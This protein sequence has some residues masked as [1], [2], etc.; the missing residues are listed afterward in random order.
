MV[1]IEGLFYKVLHMHVQVNKTIFQSFSY[2]RIKAGWTTKV[3]AK[4]VKQY[5]MLIYKSFRKPKRKN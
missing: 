4:D 2:K 1:R 3:E 5:P